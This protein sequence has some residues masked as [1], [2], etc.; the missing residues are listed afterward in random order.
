MPPATLR[1]P[2]KPRCAGGLSPQ[3]NEG[4]RPSLTSNGAPL[5]ILLCCL[6][7][8]CQGAPTPGTSHCPCH[9]SSFGSPT[10]EGTFLR[11]LFSLSLSLSLSVFI[12]FVWFLFFLFFLIPSVFFFSLPFEKNPNGNIQFHFLLSRSREEGEG[13]AM[14]PRF[15]PRCFSFL[16][17]DFFSFPS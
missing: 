12:F 8:G 10:L 17:H 5:H 7:C 6:G 1:V 11:Q 2:A 16:Y 3:R 15:S 9:M 13:R 4:T 14:K